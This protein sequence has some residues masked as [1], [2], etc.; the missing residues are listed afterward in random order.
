MP[1]SIP[2]LKAQLAAVG[3]APELQLQK[4]TLDDAMALMDD[5]DFSALSPED[6]TSQFDS[7][8]DTLTEQTEVLSAKATA[9]APKLTSMT[10][11]MMETIDTPA[12][13][14]SLQ[15]VMDGIEIPSISGG[16]S[17]PT[18]GFDKFTTGFDVPGVSSLGNFDVT[19]ALDV[20]SNKLS[21]VSISG[22]DTMMPDIGAG[23]AALGFEVPGGLTEGISGG[24]EN[25]FKTFGNFQL[26]DS[27]DALGNPIQELI[28]KGVPSIVP[29]FDSRVEPIAPD[30]EA[31]KPKITDM[32]NKLGPLYKS[33]TEEL[34]ATIEELTPVLESA[35]EDLTPAL[36]SA[37]ENLTPALQELTTTIEV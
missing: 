8:T 6:I 28:K 27:F 30:I 16:L 32:I 37:V 11:K 24:L 17:L 2:D 33:T 14:D 18:G 34:S 31:L 20:A 21:E 4:K 3:E 35:V 13:A 19:S 1:I 12:L 10:E 5:V 29:G 22:F 25:P 23:T 15:G 7:V 9:L 26:K 36:E